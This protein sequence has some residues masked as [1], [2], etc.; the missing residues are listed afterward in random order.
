MNPILSVIIPVYNHGPY[1]KQAINSV[2]MQKTQ[3]SL[4]VII[5]EDCS[6]DNS[7]EVLRQLEK[8]LPT[9]FKILYR[10]HNMF[11]YKIDN[12]ADLFRHC[13]GKYII[14]LEGDDYWT[15]PNKLEKQISFLEKHPEY[16]AVA[17]NCVVVDEN[18]K[19]NG[20][21]YP[22]CKDQEC[23]YR[24]Y[25]SDI[26]PGQTATVMY[27]NFFYDVD[28]KKEYPEIPKGTP[29]DRCIYLM[30]LANGRIYCMQEIMSA[31]RHVTT[32]GSS[33]S[34]TYQADFERDFKWLLAIL[35]YLKKNK[36]EWSKYAKMLLISYLLG[37]LIRTKRCS[38]INFIKKMIKYNLWT[39]WHIYLVFYIRKHIGKSNI[40]I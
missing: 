37:N 7:R 6:T 3:Y 25:F 14:I 28:F 10:E 36:K 13:S 18:S 35:E 20:E 2:L 9:Y 27:R 39:A 23:T 4:E 31:Y 32:N 16:Y 22:E 30:L 40:Y 38:L 8:E 24:H 33:F 26:L 34:A 29:L 11:N 19:P 12:I 17:H 1:I 5:G 21:T 15:D